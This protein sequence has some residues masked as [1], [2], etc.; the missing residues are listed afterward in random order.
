ML[1]H[2]VIDEF[3]WIKIQYR[4]Y[5][6]NSDIVY[7]SVISCVSVFVFFL[8]YMHITIMGDP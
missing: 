3:T 6:S 2:I 1:N 5:F 4:T 7:D 8:I